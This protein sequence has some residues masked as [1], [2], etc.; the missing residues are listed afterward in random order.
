M[1]TLGAAARTPCPFPFITTCFVVGASC[2]PDLGTCALVVEEN[3]A[4]RHDKR[5]NNNGNI[6]LPV[7]GN[8]VSSH[9]AAGITVLDITDLENARYCFVDFHGIAS[10]RQAPL[11]TPLDGLTYLREY[12]DDSDGMVIRNKAATDGLEK[13]GLVELA[14]LA[15]WLNIS[16]FPPKGCC[17]GSQLSK[18]RA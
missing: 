8:P 2:N 9:E 15:G 13:Y 16:V 6:V 12:Y 4:M 17:L 7:D 5:H 1:E 14:A 18:A 11:H 10:R 3:F